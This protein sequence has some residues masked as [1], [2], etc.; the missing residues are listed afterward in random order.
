MAGP[1][2]LL[3]IGFITMFSALTAVAVGSVD[4]GYAGM[5]SAVT[6]LVRETGQSLGPAIVSA[7]ALGTAGSS[8]AGRL[9]SSGLPPQALAVAHAVLSQGGPLAVANANLGPLS[10]TVAPMARASLEQGL[11]TGM[12]VAA[13]AS[14]VAAV[15]A[16][17]GLRHSGAADAPA[18][19]HADAEADGRTPPPADQPEAREFA[20]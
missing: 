5:A 16:L 12:Y 19:L 14:I 4:I 2:L 10:K 6:S 7:I 18:G 9:A 17:L 1:I 13:G 3:G 15:I 20:S 8:L 11:D